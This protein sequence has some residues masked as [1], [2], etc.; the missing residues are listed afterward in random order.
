[1]VLRKLNCIF[2]ITLMLISLVPSVFAA[3]NVEINLKWQT[4]GADGKNLTV[5]SVQEVDFRV[6]YYSTDAIDLSD[7]ILNRQINLLRF[8]ENVGTDSN[9]QWDFVNNPTWNCDEDNS[10][11]QN[12]LLTYN[13]NFTPLEL[14]NYRIRSAG[15][16][17][18]GMGTDTIYLN[19]IP[20]TQPNT[21]PEAIF[22]WDP[23]TPEV[24]SRVH[25]DAS[26]SYD[27]ID[28]EI[29]NTGLEYAWDFNGDGII[30]S[31]DQ[32]YTYRFIEAGRHPV[33][34]TVT[35]TDGSTD[36]L[37]K[38][39]LVARPTTIENTAPE[40]DFSWSPAHPLTYQ[41]ITLI[42]LSYDIVNGER[43]Y[44][45]LTYAWDFG[46]GQTS[47]EQ[48]PTHIFTTEGDHEITLTVS[49]GELIDS[50]TKTLTI[51]EDHNISPVARNID[52]D[53]EEDTPVN[54]IFDCTDGNDDPLTYE[55]F[56][57][58]VNG[59]LSGLGREVTYT[60]NE[61]YNGRDFFIYRCSDDSSYDD[62]EVEITIT[63]VD[64][65]M[66][67]RFD[68]DLERPL[69]DQ[70][71]TFNDLSEDVD[72]QIVGWYWDFGD[73][74]NYQNQDAT[75]TYIE[76]GIYSVTL[77]VENDIGEEARVTHQVRV[78]DSGDN[79]VPEINI[80]TEDQEQ[81]VDEAQTLTF[82]VADYASDADGDVLTY[83]ARANVNL[84]S[85][86][87]GWLFNKGDLNIP[88]AEF[89][90]GTGVFT[91]T[92]SYDFVE[93][94][95]N[96]I[97]KLLFG[98]K[99]TE[100]FE[101]KFRAY[102]GQDYSE[103]QTLTIT[104]NDVNRDPVIVYVDVP[105]LV[106]PKSMVQFSA[107]LVEDADG[108]SLTYQWNF[109]VQDSDNPFTRPGYVP[110]SNPDYQADAEGKVVTHTYD[111][112]GEYTVALLVTDNYGGKDLWIGTITVKEEVITD[113]LGCTA[114]DA[115]NYNSAA[116]INDGSC[117]YDSDYGCTDET[118]IN[119]N[120]AATID[121]GS[122]VYDSDYGCTDE[123]ALNYN[124]EATIDDGSCVYDSDY[125]CIDESALNYNPLA[126]ID[127]NS[128]EYPK[129]RQ[130]IYFQK[131][132]LS[133][134][135]LSTE[136]TLY[137]SMRV[138]N[139]GNMDVEGLRIIVTAPELGIRRATEKFDLDSENHKNQGLAL[140]M[141]YLVQPGKYLLKFSVSNDYFHDTTYREVVII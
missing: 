48:S 85:L 51:I 132:H 100:E 54:I 20:P 113:V 131:V 56:R 24:F 122:C 19:V 17:V 71:I 4:E 78:G 50:N 91:F 93:H 16:S 97:E 118:A 106:T 99:L 83:Q 114:E 53:T 69:I 81:E 9:P 7:I 55:I 27:L 79:N 86:I 26:W 12:G 35:D 43:V 120:S 21:K 111:Q 42:D 60:P 77:I 65:I 137:L 29:V 141:P 32:K 18:Y 74:T 72:N 14:G 119:Y 57:Q 52:E 31:Y 90:D 136:D 11:I 2:L 67:A 10:L 128:C 80:P 125:G 104:V 89:N 62:G 134:E 107:S 130:N 47:T 82:N 84:L 25:F 96:L 38:S 46:D 40:A 39:I 110:A 95:K 15:Y 103:W 73:N 1:M 6:N 108:D 88:G 109:D 58:P 98:N 121:D 101:V 117:V 70:E 105:E 44:D 13:C 34:L 102:D 66:T 129:F 76:A 140:Q 75:H 36:S 61:N 8:E 59:Q 127:D 45:G 94:A 124:S 49:D 23:R 68:W 126:T 92:P 63:P 30:E 28:G 139:N 135:E 115:I 5:T 22:T 133:I 3:N 64:D 41:E 37:T 112:V 33:T 123:N 87:T 116:T 138:A